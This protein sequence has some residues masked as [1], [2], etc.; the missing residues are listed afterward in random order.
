[1]PQ[2]SLHK[3]KTG[4]SA[5]L[6]GTAIRVYDIASTLSGTPA[7]ARKDT[8]SEDQLAPESGRHEAARLALPFARLVGD[9]NTRF[10]PD[11]DSLASGNSA[12]Q[13]VAGERWALD[14]MRYYSRFGYEPRARVLGDIIRDSLEDGGIAGEHFRGLVRV[15]D[16]MLAFAA[17][18]SDLETYAKD[19]QADHDRTLAAWAALTARV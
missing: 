10:W 3:R 2:I 14:L 13:R 1:V 5:P 9:G 18:Q 8:P 11:G 4:L 17:S 12:E 6:A 15:L 16:A 19:L 7:V